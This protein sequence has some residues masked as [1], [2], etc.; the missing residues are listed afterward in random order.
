MIELLLE[1]LNRLGTTSDFLAIVYLNRPGRPDVRAA[2]AARFPEGT[3]FTDRRIDLSA[4]TA[5]EAQASASSNR[6]LRRVK[7]VR[8]MVGAKRYKALVLAQ[9]LGEGCQGIVEWPPWAM[10]IWGSKYPSPM[11]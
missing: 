11:K 6:W 8:K 5:G 9:G 3:A 7:D 4:Q 10:K 1:R 2:I